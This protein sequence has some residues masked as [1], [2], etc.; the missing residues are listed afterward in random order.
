VLAEDMELRE[1]M[2]VGEMMAKKKAQV[3]LDRAMTLKGQYD[4]NPED[5]LGHGLKSIA[6]AI[7][8]VTA[9]EEAVAKVA[10]RDKVLSEQLSEIR[11][12]FFQ[13]SGVEWSG[14][15]CGAGMSVF[16]DVC[17]CFADLFVVSG[18]FFC[19]FWWSSVSVCCC[20]CYYGGCVV[21]VVVVVV[22]VLLMLLLLLLMLLSC[23]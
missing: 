13:V 5:V 9:A 17:F 14:V 3:A 12:Q 20:C 15:E 10:A 6:E 19:C 22:V 4:A 11:G 18:S 23:Y 1:D 7:A 2:L 8:L 16:W 21:V